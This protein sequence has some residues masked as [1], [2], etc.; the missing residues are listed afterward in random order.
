MDSPATADG[1]LDLLP[2]VVFAAAQKAREQVEAESALQTAMI[3]ST[4]THVEARLAVCY[5]EHM[6]ELATETTCRQRRGAL[7]ALHI[8]PIPRWIF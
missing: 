4:R 1:F 8:P 5:A 7:R 3:S 2:E 6:E